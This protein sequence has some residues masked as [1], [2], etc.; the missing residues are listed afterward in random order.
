[1]KIN[2][3]VR[4]IY[5]SPDST[6]N[7]CN[8]NGKT[9]N[10]HTFCLDF[11][12]LSYKQKCAENLLNVKNGKYWPTIRLLVLKCFALELCQTK[13]KNFICYI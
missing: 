1:M 8:E 2:F 9:C 3:A 5:K 4:T 13:N 11:S 10:V 6:T 7:Q 12:I